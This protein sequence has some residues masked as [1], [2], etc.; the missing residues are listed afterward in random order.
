MSVAIVGVILTVGGLALLLAAHARRS[1]ILP[2][3]AKPL[4]STGFIVAALGLG[5]L[6]SW[7]GALVLVALCF[8]WLGDVLLIPQGHRG[9]F[10]AGLFSFLLGHLVLMAAFLVHGVHAAWLIAGAAALAL[11]MTLIGRGLAPHVP[12]ALRA[13][14][15]TYMAVIGLMVAASLGV[16]GAGGPMAVL[17]G[18][19]A[20]AASDIAV[21]RHR[22]VSPGLS[23]KLW[24]LPL[25][26][27]GVLLL[28]WSV[29]L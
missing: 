13:P 21:A 27:C 4:A 19:A 8:C 7:Y 25:Y 29:A 11:L 23:N 5:A 2:W 1:S 6:Q 26:Y 9:T 10:A 16:V 17:A 15:F 28:A 18:A 14:V 20:F 22:F 12:G 24:G 3:I